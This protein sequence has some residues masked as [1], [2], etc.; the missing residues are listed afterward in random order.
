MLL[1][2]G[3]NDILLNLSLKRLLVETGKYGT[4]EQINMD[5][6]SLC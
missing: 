6:Y 3:D 1:I 4:I 5:Y 2:M